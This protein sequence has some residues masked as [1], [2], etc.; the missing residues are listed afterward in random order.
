MPLLWFHYPPRKL[1]EIEPCTTSETDGARGR[2][3]KERSEFEIPCSTS[4][5]SARASL[6]PIITFSVITFSLHFNQYKLWSLFHATHE[7]S[8][9]NSALESSADKRPPSTVM[10]D[11]YGLLSLSV[12]AGAHGR[13]ARCLKAQQLDVKIQ[14]RLTNAKALG[15]YSFCHITS[16]FMKFFSLPARHPRVCQLSTRRR[17]REEKKARRIFL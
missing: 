11:I 10:R 1:Y 12:I 3:G 9:N 5:A 2:S 8:G 4:K 13:A 15:K 17:A 16:L 14:L 6:I 7:F